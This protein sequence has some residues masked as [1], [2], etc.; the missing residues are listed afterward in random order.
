MSDAGSKDTATT[1]ASAKK[2]VKYVY[3]LYL[4]D[5][6]KFYSSVKAVDAAMRAHLDDKHKGV[7]LE[8]KLKELKE[9]KAQV[10]AAEYGQK[11]AVATLKGDKD[12]LVTVTKHKIENGEE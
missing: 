9:F 7:E 3:E 12:P 1:S 10:K 8:D 6:R 4:G 2:A 5:V 11:I